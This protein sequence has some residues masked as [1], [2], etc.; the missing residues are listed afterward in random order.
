MSLATLLP[1]KTISAMPP[2]AVYF[3]ILQR[4]WFTLIDNV[5]SLF[6][7]AAWSIYC[8]KKNIVKTIIKLGSTPSQSK[9]FSSRPSGYITPKLNYLKIKYFHKPLSFVLL[10]IILLSCGVATKRRINKPLPNLNRSLIY[11]AR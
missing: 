7:F 4:F 6:R 1:Q 10:N 2:P 3:Y 9:C 11:Q 8:N 5:S